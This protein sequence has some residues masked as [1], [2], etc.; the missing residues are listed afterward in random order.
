MNNNS[1]LD[2]G[3][4]LNICY[5]HPKKQIQL[6]IHW[7]LHP[8]PSKEPSFEE[9]WKRK[10]KSRLSTNSVYFLDKEYLY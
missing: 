3:S 4:I 9:L 7:R 6:E 1:N 8:R 5:F 10:R 2:L